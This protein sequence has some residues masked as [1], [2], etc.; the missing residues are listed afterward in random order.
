MN[1]QT[2]DK[3]KDYGNALVDKGEEGWVAFYALT[4]YIDSLTV[5][6]EPKC[7]SADS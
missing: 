7:H 4:D 3:I 2:R 5:E 1:K 6:D